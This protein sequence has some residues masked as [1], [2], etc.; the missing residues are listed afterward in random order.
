MG[1]LAP[2]SENPLPATV[3][4]LTVTAAAPVEV[5]VT[6]SVPPVF[7]FSL[8]KARLV[9][10]TFSMI[11]DAPSCKPTVLVMPPALADNV[12]ACAT[13]TA[14]TEAVKLA[15][16][17]PTGNVTEDGTV[18]AEL[19]LARFIV[20]PPLIAAPL[21]VTVQLS[22]PAPVIDPLV[23]LSALSTG[24]PLPC[25][26]IRFVVPSTELLF[27]VNW[28]VAEPVAVGSNCNV[29]VAV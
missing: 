11:T 19:L 27:S 29:T 20:R 16:V 2:D 28:P 18:T 22:L 24:T 5:K 6:G 7:T 8:P 23:Q 12:T 21:S 9:V 3:A 17:A 15:L 13:L 26:P 1:K 14:E 4:A 10:L 25:N